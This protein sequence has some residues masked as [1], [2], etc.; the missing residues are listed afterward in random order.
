MLF[1]IGPGHRDAGPDVLPRVDMSKHY[2]SP[3]LEG[4][5]QICF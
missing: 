1:S 2:L 5:E 3:E 4:A